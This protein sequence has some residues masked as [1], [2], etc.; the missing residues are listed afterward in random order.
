MPP[1][2]RHLGEDE[3]G[4]GVTRLVAVAEGTGGRETE[5]R[6]ARSVDAHSGVWRGLL[7]LRGRGCFSSFL[8]IFPLLLSPFLRRPFARP[9]P[10]S[11][12]PYPA[13]FI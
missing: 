3:G 8:A 7:V 10:V 9:F 5:W 1:L 2:Q 6:D 11:C 12:Y 4:R 13:R